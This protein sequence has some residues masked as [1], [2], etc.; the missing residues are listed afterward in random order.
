MVVESQPPEVFHNSSAIARY[1]FYV[2]TL[3]QRSSK[4]EM[5]TF[6]D[7]KKIH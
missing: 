7:T 5:V 1:N 6:L 3:T 4:A 2:L